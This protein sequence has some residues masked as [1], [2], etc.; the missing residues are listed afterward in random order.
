MRSK[1]G[2]LLPQAGCLRTK[3]GNAGGTTAL[4]VGGDVLPQAGCLR[5]RVYLSGWNADL[6]EFCLH[7]RKQVVLLRHKMSVNTDNGKE[8][9]EN[10]KKVR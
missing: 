10:G 8:N 2:N 6:C 3:W 9:A 4:Q 7:S 1:W 5:T